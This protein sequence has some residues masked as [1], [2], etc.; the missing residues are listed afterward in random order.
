MLVISIVAAR[1]TVP[2]L[3]VPSAPSAR[4][5]M[6]GIALVLMLVAQFEVRALASGHLDQGL[7]RYARPCVGDGLLRNAWGVC[8]P[9]ASGGQEMRT[10]SHGGI[11][12]PDR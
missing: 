12:A 3:A 11:D 5:V 10:L 4:L 6:G 8:H 2:R 9:A 1:W 7:Y